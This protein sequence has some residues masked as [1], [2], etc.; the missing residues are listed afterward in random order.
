MYLFLP[1]GAVSMMWLVG[2]TAEHTAAETSKTSRELPLVS[3]I[4]TYR[5]TTS[6]DDSRRGLE[7]PNFILWHI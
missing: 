4:S 5:D 2:W 3:Y 7:H 6:R 1:Y